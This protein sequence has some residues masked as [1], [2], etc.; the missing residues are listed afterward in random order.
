VLTDF[1]RSNCNASRYYFLLYSLPLKHP[2]FSQLAHGIFSTF[3]YRYQLA[4]T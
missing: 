2:D 4:L 1:D 3:D